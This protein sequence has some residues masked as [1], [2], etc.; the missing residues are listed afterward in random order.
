MTVTRRDVT[1]LAAPPLLDT[2]RAQTAA[3]LVRDLVATTIEQIERVVG[4][5]TLLESDPHDGSAAFRGSVPAPGR[6]ISVDTQAL[7]AISVEIL[8]LRE[9]GRERRLAPLLDRVAA[10]SPAPDATPE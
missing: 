6:A 3:E 5:V 1:P 9:A 8:R 10:A 2:V 7:L 4:L